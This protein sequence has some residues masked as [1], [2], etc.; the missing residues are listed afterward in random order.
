MKRVRRVSHIGSFQ[1]TLLPSDVNTSCK[2]EDN[3][4]QDERDEV[5]WS[6]DTLSFPLR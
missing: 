5:D 1:L 2:E 6:G 4:E 3:E